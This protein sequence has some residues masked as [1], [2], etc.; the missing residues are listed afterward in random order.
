MTISKK[1]LALGALI[2]AGIGTAA[3]Y[4]LSSENLFIGLIHHGFLAATVGGLADW[5]GITALFH[6]PLGISYHTNVLINNRKRIET[7]LSE[8]ICN[9]LLSVENILEA[10][11]GVS[12]AQLILDHFNSP[13]GK[14]AIRKIAK[15]LIENFL[16]K[17][18]LTSFKQLA[19]NEIPQAIEKLNLPK[20]IL[21]LIE[22]IIR[23][24]Y[25]NPSMDL[26]LV[27]L[28]KYVVH[29]EDF[30][31]IIAHLIDQASQKYT[32][33][34]IL[35]QLFAKISVVEIT[36]QCLNTAKNYLQELRNPNHELRSRLK[37]LALEKISTLRNSEDFHNKVNGIALQIVL[38]KSLPLE[39]LLLTK[40]TK[41][42]YEYFETKLNSLEKNDI[43][44]AKLDSFMRNALAKILEK[45]HNAISKL[46][47]NKLASYSDD[48]LVDSIESRIGDD[49]QM[50]RLNGTIVG[51][52]AGMM[53]YVI[54]IIAERM[55][56]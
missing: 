9:D 4:N 12:L 32:E 6:E 2:A 18:D 39:E 50:I 56:S 51:G 23:K 5:F 8:F 28:K 3:T 54:T 35:R 13:K 31:N 45:K 36:E 37:S 10:L 55:W 47:T 48:E 15:P 53:L 43:C 40:D 30:K 24:D 52:F 20:A 26:V 22:Q 33:D 25:L 14:A 41:P 29:D 19:T 44:K 21:D 38:N 49:L 27:T 17:T 42:L 16:S 7:D 46:V 1:N 11:K 34:M